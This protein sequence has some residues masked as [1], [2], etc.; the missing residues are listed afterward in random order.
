MTWG[1]SDLRGKPVAGT[2]YPKNELDFAR[3]F[4]SEDD[5]R[6]YL[7]AVRFRSGFFCVHCGK[8][9]P[10]RR[11]EDAWWCS[12]CRRSFTLTTGT[13]M[14]RTHTPLEVWLRVAWHMVNAK[15]GVA[16]L[17]LSRS[18]GISYKNALYLTHKVRWAMAQS[19]ERLKGTVEMDE[20]FI[21][22]HEPGGQGAQR[23]TSNKATVLVAVERRECTAFRPRAKHKKKVTLVVAGRA[24]MRRAYNNSTYCLEEFIE[25]NIEPGSVLRTDGH[26]EYGAAIRRLA[27]RGLDYTH[28]PVS[29]KASPEDAHELLPVVH[30][31]IRLVK[32]THGAVHKAAILEHQLDGYL[33]EFVFRYN[34]RN[35]QSRGLVFW[36]LICRLVETTQVTQAEIASRKAILEEA[37]K[38]TAMLVE[39]VQLEEK[40][41]RNRGDQ[42]KWRERHAAGVSLANS[43]A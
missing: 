1:W 35:S 43:R 40:R 25:E 41:R 9:N 38:R 30:R 2:H 3:W 31:A 28:F 33:D 16:A 23:A 18:F 37:D 13:A 12:A 11:S 36:R 5:A 17:T 34:R 42:R 20:T 21:G 10:R 8:E 15:S 29:V 19:Q 26:P 39:E 32:D 7:V 6:R 22:G 14:H 4:T 24:R 27:E